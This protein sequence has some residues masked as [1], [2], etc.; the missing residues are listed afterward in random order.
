MIHMNTIQAGA[1]PWTYPYRTLRSQIWS[2]SAGGAGIL[3]MH[4][5]L[6]DSTYTYIYIY[7]HSSHIHIQGYYAN[8][9]KAQGKD[10]GNCK[11]NWDSIAAC[12][13]YVLGGGGGGFL[14]PWSLFEHLEYLGP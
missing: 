8:N 11:R 13:N 5:L 10:S 4:S 6:R 12:R 14:K 3:K 1:S 2:L 7:I 9:G